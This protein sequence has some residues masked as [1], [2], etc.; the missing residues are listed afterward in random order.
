MYETLQFFLP[1][2]SI[3]YVCPW[4]QYLKWVFCFEG[5]AGSVPQTNIKQNANLWH[6]PETKRCSK[7]SL[8]IQMTSDLHRFSSSHQH[9]HIRE[10]C[11]RT[12]GRVGHWRRES[13]GTA[14]RTWVW[15]GGSSES[16]PGSFLQGEHHC[17]QDPNQPP[18]DVCFQVI[19][20]FCCNKMHKEADMAIVVIL[21]WGLTR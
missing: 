15:C 18:D 19:T 5:C 13:L 10:W 1:H 11:P 14:Q 16:S 17:C 6:D 3:N 2:H 4:E 9:R 12:A 20:E 7:L 8:F 21:R